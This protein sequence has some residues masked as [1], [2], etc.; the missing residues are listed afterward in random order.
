MTMVIMMMRMTMM[1][2]IMTMMAIMN[3]MYFL[4]LKGPHTGLAPGGTDKL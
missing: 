2:M 1:M 3:I 4:H